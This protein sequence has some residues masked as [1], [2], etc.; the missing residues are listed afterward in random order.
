VRCDVIRSTT[1]FE[2]AD[3][4]T[5]RREDITADNKD[6]AFVNNTPVRDVKPGAPKTAG[7]SLGLSIRKRLNL[8]VLDMSL[9]NKGDVR[10]G[11]GSE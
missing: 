5:D 1:Y 9:I 4:T 10:F 8:I 3:P 6:L 2:M 7:I 11:G